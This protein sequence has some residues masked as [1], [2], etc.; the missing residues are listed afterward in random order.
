MTAEEEVRRGD[1]A[2]QLLRHPL[3][4]EAFNTLDAWLRQER[5]RADPRDS[6]YHSDLIRY[7]QLLARFQDH[8]RAV[9]MSG[10]AA[11]LALRERE[12][13][14]QRLAHAMR[15]GIRNAI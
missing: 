3:V 4:K 14:G 6:R 13:M 11:S 7:E 5:E 12:S 10:E 1:E 8:F 2:E 9:I 15:Y